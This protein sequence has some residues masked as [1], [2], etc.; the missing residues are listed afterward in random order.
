MAVQERELTEK[1]KTLRVRVVD[2]AKDGEPVVN[3]KMPVRVVKF[4]LKMA[5]AF[6]PQM[7]DVDLDWDAIDDMIEEGAL[8][9]IVDVDDEIEHKTVEVWLE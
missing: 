6:A 9:K 4:G 8:G 3:I 7:K 1:P 5:K 2:K